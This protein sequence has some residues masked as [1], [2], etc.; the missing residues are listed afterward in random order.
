MDPNRAA[1]LMDAPASVTVVARSC[2]E[3]DAWATALMVLGVEAGVTRARECGLDALLLVRDDAANIR[4]VGV[5]P[6]FSSAP[7]PPS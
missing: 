1:P 4:A 3:A 5:G 6:L 7:C 2:A